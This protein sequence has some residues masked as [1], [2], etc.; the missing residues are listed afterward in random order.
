MKRTHRI[1]VSPDGQE[2]AT[3]WRQTVAMGASPW[4]A[5][6]SHPKS[7]G[8]TEIRHKHPPQKCVFQKSHGVATD[9]SHG[10]QPMDRKPQPSKVPKGRQKSATNIG[11]KSACSR[12]ATEWRQT[13]AMGVSPWNASPSHPMSRRDDRNPPQTSATKVRVPEKPRSGDRQ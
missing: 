1:I 10:H 9:N 5:S 2:L 11:H 3:E 8:T 6:P 7:A 13:V 4:N 12:K